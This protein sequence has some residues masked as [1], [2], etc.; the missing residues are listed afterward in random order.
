MATAVSAEARKRPVRMGTGAKGQIRLIIQLHPR[1]QN[2]N[3]L[4]AQ[5][6]LNVLI[7]EAATTSQKNRG[8]EWALR[9]GQVLTLPGRR[10]G[11]ASTKKEKSDGY[12]EH[13]Q[14]IKE[15]SELGC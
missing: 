6:K 4:L 12:D 8:S 2:L 7:T 13:E 15:H 11:H 1:P 5:Q 9:Q 14:Y 10:S 3:Q